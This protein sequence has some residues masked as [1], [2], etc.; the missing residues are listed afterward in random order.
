MPWLTHAHKAR[1]FFYYSYHNIDIQP[2]SIHCC[3]LLLHQKALR[4]CCSRLVEN[5]IHIV[6]ETNWVHPIFIPF[7]IISQYLIDLLTIFRR[8]TTFQSVDW[9]SKLAYRLVTLP[10]LHL[11]WLPYWV[12]LPFPPYLYDHSKSNFWCWVCLIVPF[13]QAISKSVVSCTPHIVGQFIMHLWFWK[14]YFP[15]Y[16]LPHCIIEM[17]VTVTNTSMVTLSVILLVWFFTKNS[18]MYVDI[19]FLK[20]SHQSDYKKENNLKVCC[21]KYTK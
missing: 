13:Y 20:N 6:L 10:Y 21:V 5:G 3:D 17:T 7:S 15:H 2:I 19:I 9:I 1:L 11:S 14:F 8:L 12:I 4:F 18:K 16:I